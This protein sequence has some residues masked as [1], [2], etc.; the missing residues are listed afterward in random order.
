MFKL[1]G[2]N[3]KVNLT[4]S[5]FSLLTFNFLAQVPISVGNQLNTFT[6]MIRGYHFTAP[7]NFT[8]CGLQVPNT[9]SQ[10]LQTIRVVRFNAAAPPAFPGNTNAF[11]QLFTITNAPNGI[12]PCN[13]PITAGQIIGVYGVRGACVNSYGPPNFVTNING[14]NTTLQRSGMQS[15]PTPG[16]APMTNIWSEVFYNIGRINMYI[17]CCAPP[18]ATATNTGP[19]CVGSPLSLSASPTPAIPLNGVYTYTWTGPNSF[20][21]NLQNPTILNPTIAASGTYT[22]T[23]NSPCGSV[24]V[25]TQVVVNPSPTATI[26]NN[27]G[28][29]IIDCNSPVI[30]VT[31]GGGTTYAWDNGLGTNSTASISSAGLYTVTV[32]NVQG[33]I[34][35]ASIAVSVAPVPTI[36]FNGATICEGQSTTLNA[37]VTPAGGLIDWN[38]GQTTTTIT[39]N[40]LQTTTYTATYT[41]N[42]CSAIDS[43]TVIVNLQPTVSVN[44][45]T[46]CNGDTT[47]LT[48]TPSIIGGTYQWSNNQTLESINVNPGLPGTTYSVVYTL[49][50][51]TAQASGTVTVNPVPVLSIAPVII[52]FGETATLTAVPN[53]PGGSFLWA[54]SGETSSSISVTPLVTTNYSA[55]YTLT[56]CTSPVASAQVTVKPLPLMEFTADTT[57]GCIPLNVT[58]TPN[59]MNPST[60]YQWISSNGFTGIAAQPQI[61]YTVGGC[62]DVSVIGTLN[63]CIDSSSVN[64]YIC[65]QNYPTAEFNVSTLLFTETSQSV[66][67]E[68]NSLGATSYVWDFG[69][70]EFSTEFSPSH[71]FMGTGSGFEITLIASTSMGCIDSTSIAIAPQQGGIYYIPN[72]FTPDGDIYNQVFKPLFTAGFDIYQYNMLIYNRWGDVI[73]ETNNLEMGWDGSFGLNGGDA[74]PGT[75]TYK[76]N[77]KVPDNDDRMIITGHVN[78]I[79]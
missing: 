35:T 53:L 16:G 67:F 59:F 78:L 58:F 74:L 50:G 45:D 54:S 60:T 39:V 65:V 23:I 49:I 40:P 47:M 38:S 28:V 63:G 70:G 56:G 32:T 57:Y 75:Y 42:G 68:N 6:S 43:A 1:V 31:A 20:T 18:T 48:A 77:I 25:S 72:S 76:I 71:L 41:W 51:C 61:L 55:T 19:I 22:C 36:T 4:I 17:N 12:I 13:I 8:I 14:F 5:L 9:A 46:I 21:S 52:C 3:L 37:A 10:G 15:C 29:N 69:D 24:Q 2:N 34:D 27:T 30:N 66:D 44:S 7:T 26:T 73:F 33:C 64:D 79:R 62:Y 11:V